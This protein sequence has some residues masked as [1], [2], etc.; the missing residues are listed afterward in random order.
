VKK[1]AEVK[2][3]EEKVTRRG[4]WWRGRWSE[5]VWEEMVHKEKEKERMVKK[6]VWKELGKGM[7]KEYKGG[8]GR[9]REGL[10]VRKRR[11]INMYVKSR[12]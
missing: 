12:K 10:R 1:E 6:V 2:V 4:E 3:E 7:E 8:R 11:K 9:V 5:K